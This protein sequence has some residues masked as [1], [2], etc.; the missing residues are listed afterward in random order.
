MLPEQCTR[1][2]FLQRTGVTAL[3]VSVANC[4]GFS[5]TGDSADS[6]PSG[7]GTST[8]FIPATI[9][10]RYRTRFSSLVN[11]VAAGA[12]N[13]GTE[14]IDSTLSAALDDDT[15]LY[16]PAGTY[17]LGPITVGEH[18]NIAF[19]SRPDDEVLIQPAVPREELDEFIHFWGVS[20][21][22][23]DGLSFDFTRPG[24]GGV[25]KLISRGDFTARNL[26]IRGKLPDTNRQK[27][28][29]GFRF[30]VRNGDSTGVVENVIATDGGHDGG[31]G[32]GIFV[33]KDHAGT[34]LFSDC[35]IANFP[36]NGLYASA[37][38]RDS[39][40]YRGRDGIVH[41]RGGHYA[42]NNIANIR[43]GSTDSTVRGATVVVDKVP[44]HPSQRTLNVRGIRIRA[45]S[46]QL[47]ENCDIRIGRDAGSGFGGISFHPDHESSVIRD[48][49]ITVERSNFNA[50]SATDADHGGTRAPLTFENVSVIGGPNGGFAVEISDRP[51]TSFDN[52]RIEQTGADRGG[53]LLRRSDNCRLV[54]CS[55]RVTGTPIELRN[56]TVERIRVTTEQLTAEEGSIESRR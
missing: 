39:A 45:R 20:D 23:L 54:D 41:V 47:V 43:I 15:L 36:N 29:V 46:G 17:R 30:D 9:L 48:T 33:G 11:V 44:P 37:P 42:N 28:H 56:S 5:P 3:S 27:N 4:M 26:R 49:T 40:D 25:I 18:R 52:C 50:I 6:N 51:E 7:T 35:V 19:L 13:S 32:V 2:D 22:L 38:G 53:I 12:D 8:G 34:L 24:F 16:F 55:I 14:R 10:N 21:V 1:R 31:T